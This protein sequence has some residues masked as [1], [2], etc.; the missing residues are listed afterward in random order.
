MPNS[1]EREGGVAPYRHFFSS[2]AATETTER[3]SALHERFAAL[4]QRAES[5]AREEMSGSSAGFYA[6]SSASQ[7]APLSAQHGNGADQL[8]AFE[9][10]SSE[11]PAGSEQ[12]TRLSHAWDEE[13]AYEDARSGVGRKKSVSE[14]SSTSHGSLAPSARS[15]ASSRSKMSSNVAWLEKIK[16]EVDMA[17]EDSEVGTQVSSRKSGRRGGPPLRRISEYGESE[18]APA[19]ARRRDGGGSAFVRH[20]LGARNQPSRED[21]VKLAAAARVSQEWPHMTTADETR[22]KSVELARGRRTA[23]AKARVAK[24]A[25]RPSSL[26]RPVSPPAPQRRAAEG[27]GSMGAP[28]EPAPPLQEVR[29]VTPYIPSAHLSV[30]SSSEVPPG[31]RKVRTG[32]GAFKLVAN[33]PTH[34][35]VHH[36]AFRGGACAKNR[37]DPRPLSASI[38]QDNLRSR[39]LQSQGRGQHGVRPL[40]ERTYLLPTKASRGWGAKAGSEEALLEAA[41]AVAATVAPKRAKSRG[42]AETLKVRVSGQSY[43]ESNVSL[44]PA[45]NQR[46]A[47]NESAAPSPDAPARPA[48]PEL[49][50]ATATSCSLRWYYR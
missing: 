21:L 34:G 50:E 17:M 9:K 6:P 22:S 14:L 30:P 25:A 3:L 24:R 20:K 47:V 33:N 12:P 35:G 5:E 36:H 27:Q 13:D 15:K 48:G 44:T 28:F 32:G 18:A 16:K 7:R 10:V 11:Q 4:R 49:E 23:P 42:A 2:M 39:S 43:A 31:M 19:Q 45:A 40:A 46:H 38:H 1:S 26:R 41:A 29:Y 37:Q 8:D